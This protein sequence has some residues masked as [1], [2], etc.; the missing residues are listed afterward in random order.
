MIRLACDSDDLSALIH[1]EIVL[2]YTD[3]IRND[4]EHQALK[5]RFPGSV[6]ELIDRGLGDPTGRSTLIDVESGARRPA[7][8]PG[9][10]DKQHKAGLRW[11]TVYGTSSTLSAVSVVMGKREGWWRW[12]AMWG[13]GL[14]VPGHQLAMLQFASD[15]MLGAKVD[16]SIVRNDDWHPQS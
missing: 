9:W 1:T 16:L 11:L 12:F 2:T 8:V 6:V 5:G 14:A 7:D 4:A 3:L 15:E 10:F 13:N